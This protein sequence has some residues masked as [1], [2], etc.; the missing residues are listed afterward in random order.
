MGKIS[1]SSQSGSTYPH[2]GLA[3]VPAL[4]LLLSVGFMS[5]GGGY[6]GD[7]SYGP[8]F[9]ALSILHLQRPGYLDHPGT[10]LQILGAVVMAVAWLLR[11]P[12]TGFA[13]PTH[14]ILTHSEL[15]Q[16]VINT[17]IALLIV[18]SNYYL[19]R[20]LHAATQSLLVA[21]VGQMSVLMATPYMPTLPQVVPETLMIATS[22][23]LMAALVP[24]AFNSRGF[25]QTGRYGAFVG[26][27]F[28]V[29]LATKITCGPL[30][31]M[32]L[33][34]RNRRTFAYA[35]GATAVAFVVSTSPAL[36]LYPGMIKYFYAILTH[37][38]H[39][40]HGN[41]GVM[42][43]LS[44]VMS[45]LRAL[46][47][48][49]AGLYLTFIVSWSLFALH[50]V[51]GKTGQS[52]A[53][54]YLAA[55]LTVGVQIV[56]VAAH[57]NQRYMQPAY[58]VTALVYPAIIYQALQATRPLRLGFISA[59]LAGLVALQAF[60]AQI[61]H[62]WLIEKIA[63]S[64][65]NRALVAKATASGCTIVPFYNAPYT[66]YKLTFGDG[67]ARY[68]HAGALMK[69][70]PTFVFYAVGTHRFENF[71]YNLSIDDA[72]AFLR[73]QKCVYLLGSVVER[74]ND[75]GIPNNLLTTIDR[76]HHGNS[77]STGIYELRISPSTK[78]QDIVPS[79]S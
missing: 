9:S 79:K 53:R 39:A 13:S 5:L 42:P 18:A 66:K 69:L 11:A 59:G 32:A 38:G 35:V 3:V 41:A 44:D 75:F 51:T 2:L 33:L 71:A 54:L 10:P 74:F 40:G 21:V 37:E 23:F 25:V 65:D 49:G 63:I 57:P 6:N 77:L 48:A 1:R 29:C 47:G 34:I 61:T 30:I 60:A 70:D 19:G 36:S 55:G 15:Y 43:P 62:E 52:L 56:L 78:W 27:I 17:I 14:D 4:I 26:A 67:T 68:A 12:F 22:T 72:M 73:R 20:K 28:G 24:A 58:A 31:C 46:F 16:Y 8:F 50:R 7:P 64:K 45:N 76:T